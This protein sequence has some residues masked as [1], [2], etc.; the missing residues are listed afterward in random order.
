MNQLSSYNYSQFIYGKIIGGSSYE[1]VAYT[2]DLTNLDE[3][4]I[5][6]NTC[7]AFFKQEIIPKP[8]NKAFGVFLHKD[9][10]VLVQASLPFLN[11]GQFAPDYHNRAFSQYRYVLIPI[12]MIVEKLKGRTFQLFS[13]VSRQPTPALKAKLE[14]N[15]DYLQIPLDELSQKELQKEVE[16]IQNCLKETDSQ[17]QPWLLSALAA[18]LN[19]QRVIIDYV[20][21]NI[22]PS[23]YLESILLLL[24]AKFR[25]NVAVAMGYL[26]DT[27]CGWAQLI[28]KFNGTPNKLSDNLI[29]LD[30]RNKNIE[31][32]N[33][34]TVE[35]A[36]VNDILYP[37]LKTP[38]RIAKLLETLDKIKGDI[39][40]LENPNYLKIIIQLIPLFP[41]EQQDDLWKKWL[42]NLNLQQWEEIIPDIK[43]DQKALFCG[44]QNLVNQIDEDSQHC[45]KLISNLLTYFS[46]ENCLLLLENNLIKNLSLA[47]KLLNY[48]L[49][50]EICI[51]ENAQLKQAIFN[52]CKAVLNTKS[53]QVGWQE[54]WKFF[55]ALALD[56]SNIVPNEQEYFNLID[57]VVAGEITAKDKEIFFRL[58]NTAFVPLMPHL[59]T[60]ENTN[61][62][63][64]LKVL[65][66]QAADLLNDLFKERAIALKNLVSLAKL[67]EME[68]EQED[69]LYIGFL[70]NWSL[71]FKEARP[72]L[73]EILKERL[74]PD[75]EFKDK[76]IAK[77]CEW[78]NNQEPK[79]IKIFSN[80]KTNTK[81]W[82]FWNELAQVLYDKPEDQAQYLDDNVGKL[83]W[84]EVLQTRLPTIASN[85]IPREN[86]LKESFAWQA[87]LT[88]NLSQG[89]LNYRLGEYALILTLCLGESE[90]TNLLNGD[91]FHYFCESLIK[92]KQVDEKLGLLITSPSVTKYFNHNDWLKLQYLCWTPGIKLELPP[93]RPDLI[94]S[95]KAE[96]VRQVQKIIK[97]EEFYTQPESTWNLLK[98]CEAWGLNLTERKEILKHA[99]PQGVDV[100]LLL[101]IFNCDSQE[102]K[103]EQDRDLLRLFIQVSPRDELESSER[104]TFFAKIFNN[105]ILSDALDNLTEW[106]EWLKKESDKQIGIEAIAQSVQSL[107]SL[108]S[109]S[110][111]N[112]YEYLPQLK[113]CSEKLDQLEFF[114]ESQLI[115]KL[116]H[117]KVSKD[118]PLR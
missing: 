54:S 8:T 59:Q 3:C 111:S 7:S 30:R 34:N 5:I 23:N 20:Q 72:L 102:I 86:F 31:G 42:D 93:G 71:S 57:A 76:S 116:V 75:K 63:K 52:V 22:N 68:A 67:T 90:K 87:L 33:Q 62:S 37:I 50:N 55:Q 98:D 25:G 26:D 96:L 103:L 105:L 88:E 97:E 43:N 10:I 91:L 13:W 110:K 95:E 17:G 39:G 108:L 24:P 113:N 4:Q 92:Q 1:T 53:R 117:N 69:S 82:T 16:T 51:L 109:S 12:D 40:T 56:K 61:L 99:H 49:H 11:N 94:P 58:F 80:F 77:T 14:G 114:K 115:N 15:L 70:Q 106:L 79:L 46:I 6:A 73:V 36:L 64:T 65:I 118:F 18:I 38:D 81:D 32:I 27:Q 48:E 45:Y 47:E 60:I 2:K 83:F 9:K 41:E 107:P 101:N 21:D 66:P 112:F 74:S 28:I 35:N 100:N 84:V 85:S 19:N 44:W 104:I 29:W 78:F 89:K